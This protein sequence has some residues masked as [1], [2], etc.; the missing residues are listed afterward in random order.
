[1]RNKVTHAEEKKK[2]QFV[3]LNVDP[4]PNYSD[5][6]KDITLHSRSLRWIWCTRESADSATLLTTSLTASRPAAQIGP[7]GFL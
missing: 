5:W 7:A 3:I 1:M 4:S 2:S 6:P